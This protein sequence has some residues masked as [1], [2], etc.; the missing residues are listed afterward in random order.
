MSGYRCYKQNKKYIKYI[1][2][3]PNHIKAYC[4]CSNQKRSAQ[5]HDREVQTKLQGLFLMK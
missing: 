2:K 1:K 5:N 3:K 4:A